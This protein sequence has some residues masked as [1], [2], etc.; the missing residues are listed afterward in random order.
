MFI[1]THAHLDFDRFD[2]DRDGV[3]Q[4]A[5]DAGVKRIVNVGADME[6]SRNSVNLAKE[7]DFIYAAVGVHPHDA[8]GINEDDYTELREL[9]QN[10]KVVAIGEIGLDYY[11]DNSPRKEQQEAFKKQLQLAK[12]LNLPVVIHSRDAK[13]DTLKI[14]EESAEG[15]QGILHCY[16]YD[17]ATAKR[18]IDMGFYLAFGGVITFNNAKDLRA[19]VKDISLE[20]ILIETD[21][22]YLTPAPHRGK[23]NESK[24]VINVAER[25]AEIKG[26]SLEEVAKVT[27]ANAKK[28]L[29]LK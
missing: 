25:I 12:E 20:D 17:L 6:S 22:P 3:I 14:L 24:F 23:R 1:D 4:A 16:A 21:A 13:E 11:Y 19:V 28:L 7:Y 26:I 5:Y 2:K 18:I 29:N 10:D 27:T 9:A 15:L 8:K